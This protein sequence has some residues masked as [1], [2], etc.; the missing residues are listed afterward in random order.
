MMSDPLASQE[1]KETYDKLRSILTGQESV[2]LYLEFLKKNNQ[3]DLLILK[4]TKVTRSCRPFAFSN[5]TPIVG[6]ARTKIINIPHRPDSAERV[7][8]LGNNIRPVSP[9]KP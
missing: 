4:N 8:A 9:R 2:K 7:H 6:C 5:L 1:T 3:V